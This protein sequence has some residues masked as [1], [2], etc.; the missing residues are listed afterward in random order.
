MEPPI[1]LSANLPAPD[2]EACNDS[3]ELNSG[4]GNFHNCFCKSRAPNWPF[5]ING[6]TISYKT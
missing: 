5:D 6:V 3:L 4:I 2:T 1:Y